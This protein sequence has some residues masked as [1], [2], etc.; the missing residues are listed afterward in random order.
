MKDVKQGKEKKIRIMTIAAAVFLGIIFFLLITLDINNAVN[1]TL[2]VYNDNQGVLA[3]EMLQKALIQAQKDAK[4]LDS[5]SISEIVS[6]FPTSSSV[7]CIFSQNDKILFLKDENTSSTLIDEKMSDYFSEDGVS[8]RDGAKY[9]V[10][11][12]ET[13]YEG[14]TYKLAVCTKQTYLLK[15]IKFDEMRLHCLGYFGIYGIALLVII[16]LAYYQLRAL[17]KKIVTLK[18]EAKDNRR[19]I[20]ELEND[21]NKNYVNSER[22]MYSFYNRSVVEEVISGM[23]KTEK[24][25]CIQVDI[26]VENLKMEHFVLITAILGRIKEGK[27]VACYWEY[28]Q[29]KILLFQSNQQEV[30][31]FINRFISKY[32]LESEEKVE[33]L[34]IVASSL[35][36]E[37]LEIQGE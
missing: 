26:T 20:E 22:D 5:D 1:K 14:N 28:N 36:N 2:A 31:G 13:Q 17:E 27:S 32:Q 12:S 33:E 35:E 34:K 10:A 6:R 15:K 25:K 3:E 16:V 30:R 37:A 29:F 11:S 23:S 18:N 7:Y 8:S 24:E 9:S 19:L 21:K 4:E